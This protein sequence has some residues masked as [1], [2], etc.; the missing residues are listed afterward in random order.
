MARQ[1]QDQ[2]ALIQFLQ[3]SH[4]QVAAVVAVH[5][6]HCETARQADQAVVLDMTT[7]LVAQS[8]VAQ[9]ILPARHHRKATTVVLELVRQKLKAAAVVLAQ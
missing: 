7:V 6:L 5:L 3:Q 8:Q 9:V 2:T 4:Q 1:P